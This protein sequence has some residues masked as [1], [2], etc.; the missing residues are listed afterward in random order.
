[1][2]RILIAL[3]IVLSPLAATAQWTPNDQYQQQMLEQQR[4][5]TAA[6]QQ[7]LLQMQSQQLQQQS[8]QFYGGT[9]CQPYEPARPF[10]SFINGFNAGRGSCR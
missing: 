3:T 6:Q 5:Q 9:N 4:Q 1:M 7:M 10:N 8:Q 2:K